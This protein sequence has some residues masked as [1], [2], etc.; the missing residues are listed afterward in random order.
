[1]NEI[2]QYVYSHCTASA[3]FARADAT[4][5]SDANTFMKRLKKKEG[6]KRFIYFL[7]T[8][9]F[10]SS[11]LE[12]KVEILQSELLQVLLKFTTFNLMT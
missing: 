10:V 3:S 6:E 11:N 1:M 4:P 9:K 7:F 12:N 8:L 5:S 2:S